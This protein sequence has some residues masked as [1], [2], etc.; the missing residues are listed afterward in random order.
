[1]SEE[2]ECPTCAKREFM[3][4]YILGRASTQVEPP[5]EP[6]QFACEAEAHWE[7]MMA[8]LGDCGE[9]WDEVMMN[10]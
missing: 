9:G 8:C 2:P 10:G 7:Y 5:K 1:M 4:A 6:G 3:I